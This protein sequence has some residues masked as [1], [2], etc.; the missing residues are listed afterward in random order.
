MNAELPG[1]RPL[2]VFCGPVQVHVGYGA[3]TLLL[4]G[5]EASAPDHRRGEFSEIAFA[6]ARAAPMPAVLRDA[7]VIG[8][9]QGS[10]D[11]TG[12]R[13]YRIEAALEGDAA[14][15][16]AWSAEVLARSVQLH[17]EAGM[18]LFGAVRPPRLSRSRR[19]LWLA[20]LLVLRLPGATRI[21]ER[22]RGGT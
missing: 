8:P 16:V 20:L 10:G 14:G 12:L 5:R 21:V 1:T 9:A 3:A 2:I 22:F 11:A 17:R 7:R 4:R 6:A 18:A 19:L 13:R 15:V